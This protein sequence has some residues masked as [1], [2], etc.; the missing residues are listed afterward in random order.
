MIAAKI[1][2]LA[3][4]DDIINSA[5]LVPS[6]PSTLPYIGS[7][8]NS[9][10]AHKP[11]SVD[12]A[13]TLV[14]P[15]TATL[16]P[17]A[18]DPYGVPV[19]T[20]SPSLDNI[21][22][23]LANIPSLSMFMGNYTNNANQSVPSYFAGKP[24]PPVPTTTGA[25][26]DH[27]DVGQLSQLVIS[28]LDPNAK[29]TL[30]SVAGSAEQPENALACWD[31]DEPDTESSNEEEED[32]GLVSAASESKGEDH[33]VATSR[34]TGPKKLVLP[35]APGGVSRRVS[36]R[37]QKKIPRAAT[38]RVSRKKGG[39]G[40]SVPQGSVVRNSWL[41]TWKGLRH[42]VLWATF[43]GRLMAL[44]KK[45][46]DRF[47]ELTF[48]VSSITNV[49]KH[50]RGKFT[51]YFRK[52]RF[53][54]M[55]HSDDIRDGWVES[56]LASR[57]QQSPD[58]P[59]LHGQISMKDIRSRAYAAV[60][61]YDLWIYPNKEGFQL[62]LASF[63]VPLNV[64]S[65]KATGKHT[66]SLITPY[67][68]FSVSVDSSKDLSSWLDC[69]SL[70][71]RNALS[72]SKVAMRILENPCN[73]VC[74]DC[75]AAN[76]EWASVNLLVVI[77]QACAGHHR[78]L[79]TNVS[80]VRSMKLD[81]NVWTE[82]LM[83]LF[84]IYG[85]HLAN[86]IWAAAVPAAEQ[87]CPES[88][89]EERSKFIQYKYG[90]GRYRRVHPLAASQSLMDQR[91]RD[92]VCCDDIEET[93]SLI[94]S[95]AK[96]RQFEIQNPSLVVIAEKAGQALQSELLRL[97]EYTEVPPHTQRFKKRASC[98]TLDEDEEE[99]ELHGKLEEDRFLF[100]V[101]NDSAACDVLD[102]R[103]VLSVFTTQN[104]SHYQFELVILGDQL[105]CHAED[106]DILTS[107]MVHIL[108]VILP[109]GVSYA[110][111]C[112][113]S[114]VSKVCVM[115]GNSA[116][117]Q[118]E[119]W[120]LLWEDGISIYP[121]VRGL[122][123]IL[124][125]ELTAVRRHE[126][127]ASKNAITLETRERSLLSLHFKETHS[128]QSWFNHLQRA[129]INQR[130]DSNRRPAPS[131]S[132]ARQPLYPSLDISGRGSVPQAIERCISHITAHGLKVEG[133]YRRCGLA[134]K[135]SRLVDALT[136]SPSSA[137][138]E[139]DEQGVL[140]AGSALK[141]YVRQNKGFIPNV[142]P[143]LQAAGVSDE[144]PRFKAYQRLL[145]QLPDVNRATLNALF[146][147]FYTVQ[148]FSQVNKMSAQNLAVVLVP[149][150]FQTLSQDLLRLTKEFIIHHTLLFLTSM[151]PGEE[152]EQIT[153][154]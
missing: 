21:V 96:V 95:G 98:S 97:N 141:Q 102:L 12:P 93:M 13:S 66:F 52:K 41:D 9:V 47:S 46:T 29:V 67:K 103:E 53:D 147:H 86:Q 110:E 20:S 138:F 149:T 94:C 150:L 127:D 39:R 124:K 23:S 99:E 82:P 65:V 40:G 51:V 105:I 92:I 4:V 112:G 145:Q 135:V 73:K 84:V 104:G 70:S 121:A 35:P 37:I 77:C 119:S 111:V 79:G 14:Y 123:P 6:A 108:K 2:S 57:S 49:K 126:I 42:N 19:S 27:T 130:P 101:E 36:N 153:V 55:A 38:I 10:A 43:N 151:D 25:A 80:K 146:A 88:S 116:S 62:G 68:T 106:D 78:A 31:V 117:C 154:L 152:E 56:L 142:Q 144:R 75:N 16:N 91:L 44:W 30:P 76:P 136:T 54:F 122:Q 24:L 11:S 140:D 137:L 50:D 131:R 63:S 22:S 60:W 133:V 72:C 107:H 34:S 87:L 100:S 143:W 61:G 15:D 74:G 120:L 3:G 83:Q 90:K 85:N 114:A 125:M 118:S 109:G 26:G 71:I 28:A 7:V 48:H 148:V 134:T 59:T 18:S 89:D 17:P 45:R 32:A 139:N 132:A 81:N 8:T 1:P 69:L 64:A 33:A 58:P 5:H 115:E 129:L 128:C 113:A